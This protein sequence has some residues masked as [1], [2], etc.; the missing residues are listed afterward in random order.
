MLIKPNG[1]ELAKKVRNNYELV[2]VISKRARQLQRGTGS[3]V[4]TNSLSNVTI[5]SLEFEEDK[6]TV[7][8]S[9]KSDK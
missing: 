4:K 5:A 1:E 9:N 2:T 3:M 6:Y 8:N 7:V